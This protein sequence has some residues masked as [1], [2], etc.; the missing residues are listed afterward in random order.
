METLYV[1]MGIGVLLVLLLAR[2][3]SADRR[4]ANDNLGAI[5]NFGRIGPRVVL[6]L[7]VMGEVMMDVVI[8]IVLRGVVIGMIGVVIVLLV[9][10]MIMFV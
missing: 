5:V 3:C 10:D 2:I 1:L 7:V 6:I 8:F 4:N 9:G